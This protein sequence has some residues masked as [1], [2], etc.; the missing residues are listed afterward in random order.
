MLLC[1]LSHTSYVCC[2][3]RS[4]SVA[5]TSGGCAGGVNTGALKI[6]TFKAT[7][8]KVKNNIKLKK[9]I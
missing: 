9:Y 1:S 3:W 4:C 6:G 5:I 7:N 8:N 2:I